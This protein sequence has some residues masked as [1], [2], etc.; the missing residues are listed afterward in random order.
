MLDLSGISSRSLIGRTLR[1]PLRLMPEGM[2]VRILQGTLKGKRWI[3]G[4]SDHGC[5]LGSYEFDKQQAIAAAVRPG[6]VCFDIGAN[7]GFYTLLF[8]ELTGP[9]GSVVAFEPVPRNRDLLRRHVAINGCGN[10]VVQELALADVDSTARF[11]QTHST[12]E[13]HLSETG[14]IS[15][16]CARI[17]SLVAARQIAPPDVMKI[18]VEGAEVAVLSGAAEVLARNKPLIFLATHGERLHEDCCRILGRLGYRL[19]PIHGTAIE[20]CA[21]I[22]ARPQ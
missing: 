2:E 18:D 19:A 4:S 8:S 12:S 21:E 6:M 22:V 20:S 9:E 15:V 14:T 10:V 3:T 5:W 16:K 7:V 11:D 13:G 1:L 17:D